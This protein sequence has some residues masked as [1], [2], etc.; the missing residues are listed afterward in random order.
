V[1]GLV[2]YQT[3]LV[4]QDVLLFP[5]TDSAEIRV[6]FGFVLPF[7]RIINGRIHAGLE[8][9]YL[10]IGCH[11]SPSLDLPVMLA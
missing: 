10:V 4:M 2:R 6:W 1:F 9:V 5:S 11:S 8:L 3:L 7:E